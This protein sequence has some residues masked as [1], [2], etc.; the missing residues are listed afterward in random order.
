[1]TVDF[2]EELHIKR[3]TDMFGKPCFFMYYDY[4]HTRTDLATNTVEIID[5]GNEVTIV[6]AVEVIDKFEP[7][8][9]DTKLGIKILLDKDEYT[10]SEEF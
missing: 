10:S 2:R 3:S 8:E 1:M 9:Q 5:F 7:T 6:Q 4:V